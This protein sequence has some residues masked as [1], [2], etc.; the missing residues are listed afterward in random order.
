MD[1]LGLWPFALPGRSNALENGSSW[2]NYYLPGL[3]VN[4]QKQ[5]VKEVVNELKWKDVRTGANEFGLGFQPP[6][7]DK[8]KDLTASQKKL[9]ND[10]FDRT[11]VPGNI[12]DR[13]NDLLYPDESKPKFCP[14]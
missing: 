2:V 5:I 14:R 9:I 6:H 10:F 13:I 7:A 8:L 3:S 4:Q 1:P 12:K 11:D